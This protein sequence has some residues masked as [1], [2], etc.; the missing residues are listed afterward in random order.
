MSRLDSI[1]YIGLANIRVQLGCE[2]QLK[3]GYI[4][5]MA[6]FPCTDGSI[7]W[8]NLRQVIAW[9]VY[10]SEDVI[11]SDSSLALDSVRKFYV[12]AFYKVPTQPAKFLRRLTVEPTMGTFFARGY[13]MKDQAPKWDK[14]LTYEQRELGCFE[15]GTNV[16][17]DLRTAL[18][19]CD[20]HPMNQW[21]G[22]SLDVLTDAKLY[23]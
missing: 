19:S 3:D 22:F 20:S 21:P 14:T 17:H 7:G 15:Q 2:G 1:P 13:V 5:G 16:C 10:A 8:S 6:G 4:K 12:V 23:W 11:R 18:G 9:V